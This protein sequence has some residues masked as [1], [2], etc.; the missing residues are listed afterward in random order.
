MAISA[1]LRRHIENGSFDAV[2]DDWLSHLAEDPHDLD[3]FAGLARPLASAGEPDRARFLLELTDDQLVENAEWELRLDLLQR[4]GLLVFEPDD[5]HEQRLRTLREIYSDHPSLEDVMEMVGLHRAVDDVPKGWAKTSRLRDLLA[6]EIGSIVWMEEKG[7]GRVEEF[8]FELKSLKIDF[9][10]APGLR[11]GFRAAPKLLRALPPEHILRRKIEDRASLEALR[12]GNPGELLLA[13]LQSY[14]QPR[15]AGEVKRDLEGLVTAGSWTSWWSAARKHPRVM[16]SG[17]GGRQS[18][19][20]AASGSEAEKEILE[21]FV[22]AD[23]DTKVALFKR[24]ADRSP[25]LLEAMSRELAATAEAEARQRP[26]IALTAW[27]ALDKA[28]VAPQDAAW[29]PDGF[30]R[31]SIDPAMLA[32]RLTDRALRDRFYRL[33]REIRDDWG[34][35]YLGAVSREEDP[36]LLNL[37]TGSLAEDEPQYL[38]SFLDQ[39]VSQPRKQ[40]AAV[41]WLAERAGD[42]ELTGGLRPLRLLQ[43]VVEA[44]RWNELKPY[45]PRLLKLWESGGPLPAL[46]SRLDEKT[47]GQAEQIIDRAPVEEYHRTP[48]LNALH[49]RF[50]ALRKVEENPL[51]ATEV[52][53]R[54]RR[55]ELRV[56]LEDEI[57][58]NRKAIEEAR[59]L[60]DLRENFE[61]KSAR[62]RHE[63]LNARVAK[64]EHDLGRVRVFDPAVPDTS[65]ARLGCRVYLEA[66]S[67]RRELTLMGPWESLPEE[68]VISYDSDIG[69]QIL[70]GSVGDGVEIDGTSYKIAEIVSSG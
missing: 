44:P 12:E 25:E 38:R 31:S 16:T 67:E 27:Y 17:T 6:F 43:L 70:G 50:P 1:P 37:L 42:E 46:L 65:Q 32:T 2:E 47:A 45:R 52:S 14:D 56:L 33:V 22:A 28:G 57:P 29:S 62:Q 53:I 20:S 8:N 60:G 64:L 3:Y 55:D 26:E 19:T 41:V 9:E 49:L 48:L 39:L 66:G 34:V 68:G 58:A 10:H 51:Y 21:T 30:L 7:A 63:Y 18:Y 23:V 59:A 35:I 4:V 40:P 69:K 15:T 24:N 5:L 36:R 54:L 61:Y 11:V 13:V